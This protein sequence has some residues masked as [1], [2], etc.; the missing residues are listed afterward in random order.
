M[1]HFISRHNRSFYHKVFSGFWAVIFVLWTMI[2]PAGAQL[3]P[4]LPAPGQKVELTSA[5]Q[6]AELKGM[7]VHPVGLKT[8]YPTGYITC[9]YKSIPCFFGGDG[10]MGC[11]N[12]DV[13]VF[14]MI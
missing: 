9:T 11:R 5:F 2:S 13:L 10:L 7:V 3:G 1:P 12:H 6:P 8:L 14:L 4:D